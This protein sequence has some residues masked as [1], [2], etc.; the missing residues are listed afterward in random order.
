MRFFLYFCTLFENNKN[1]SAGLET[2][3][4]AKLSENCQGKTIDL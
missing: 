3:L 1:A 2:A 4:N